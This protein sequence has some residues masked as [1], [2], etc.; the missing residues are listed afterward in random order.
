MIFTVAMIVR[1]GERLATHTGLP[2]GFLGDANPDLMPYLS[3]VRVV[4]P[5]AAAVWRIDGLRMGGALQG[6]WFNWASS[7]RAV[8]ILPPANIG[9]GISEWQQAHVTPGIPLADSS[10]PGCGS[11]WVNS[12]T[13]RWIA[14]PFAPADYEVVAHFNIVQHPFLKS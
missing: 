10:V 2:A 12:T 13:L 11:S 8:E 1:A 6:A 9:S 14:D 4:V 5:S 7:A 3:L